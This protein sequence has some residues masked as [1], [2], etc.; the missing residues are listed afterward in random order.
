V[1]M[2]LANAQSV[3]L[4]SCSPAMDHVQCVLKDVCS[5]TRL[6]N[7]RSAPL[8]SISMVNNVPLAP[9][10]VPP[11]TKRD[12]SPVLLATLNP[13]A[14]NVLLDAGA[15][16]LVTYVRCVYLG[17]SCFPP[18]APLLDCQYATLVQIPVSFVKDPLLVSAAP[19]D[20]V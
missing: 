16:L 18:M 9:R 12:A 7:V 13:I 4:V 17:T 1:E 20:T 11:V 5:V 15:A 2:D 8:L 6:H 19:L 10:G 3:I 14:L